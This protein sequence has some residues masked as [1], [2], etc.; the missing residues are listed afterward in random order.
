MPNNIQ[1]PE[2]FLC[3]ISREIMQDPVIA[4]DNHTYERDNIEAWFARSDNS[5]MTGVQLSDKSLRDNIALRQSIE[6]FQQLASVQSRQ[7]SS[8]HESSA[9]ASTSTALVPADQVGH[10]NEVLTRL[11]DHIEE[12]DRRQRRIETSLDEVRR[13]LHELRDENRELRTQLCEAQTR[14]AEPAR[15]SYSSDSERSVVMVDP[16][17]MMMSAH[18]LQ[19][20]HGY[21]PGMFGGND[22]AELLV[23]DH[24]IND[25]DNCRIS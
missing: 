21:S 12:Q 10:N 19:P 9:Q 24:V 7:Q 8:S 22:L 2:T 18:A 3:P 13:D 15:R 25:G 5:P 14:V 4:S 16:F 1:T 23:L 20:R 11:M 17:A 6:Q